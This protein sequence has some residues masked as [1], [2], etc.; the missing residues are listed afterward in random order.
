ML[1]SADAPHGGRTTA[2]GLSGF[3]QTSPTLGLVAIAAVAYYLGSIIG[4]PLRLRPSTTSVL[5][6]PNAILTA[7][8][9][10]VPI[11]RWWS[12]L[13][14]AAIAH[15]AIQLRVW[16]PEFVVSIFWTN[17]SEA[18][19]AAGV[20]RFLSDEP[21]RFD[22]LRRAS[23]FIMGA[24]AG[25]FFS[26]FLDAAVVTYFHH[27][28]YWAVWRLRFLSNLLA[29]LA[30]VSAIAGFLN[31][32]HR[33]RNWPIRVRLE[34]L[35]IGAGL[36][37]VSL[38]ARVDA[39]PIGLSNIALAFIPLLLWA[40]ARFGSA[41]VGMSVLGMVLF[42]TLDALYASRVLPLVPS[43][44]RVMALQWFLIAATVLLLCVGALVEER[45][46][47][48]EALR[49]ADRLKLSILAAVP[50]LL[51]VLR[52]D[53]TYVDYHARDPK[54]LFAPPASFIG[55][56]IRDVM[57]PDLATLFMDAL[58]RASQSDD[59][60]VVEYE[61]PM[62]DMTRK[63]EARIVRMAPDQLLTIVRDLTESKRAGELVHH[64]AG[65]LIA[66]QESERR[67]I[68]RELHDDLSQKIALLSIGIDQLAGEF[69]PAREH[70]NELTYRARAIAS[71][72]RTI[73]HELH[74]ARLE[75]VGLAPALRTL[76]LEMSRQTGVHVL[77]NGTPLPDSLDPEV[78]LS[79]YRIAQ[80]ALHNVARHSGARSADVQLT[81][82]DDVLTLQ[83]SDSGKGFRL[84]DHHA[85]LGLISMRERIAFMRGQ[86]VIQT[87]PGRGT[88]IR[89]QVP[90][91]L[92]SPP[93]VT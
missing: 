35:L 49:E 47:A 44:V 86:L 72:V 59:P 56:K 19:I 27:E 7:L 9:L 80:E 20:I 25:S 79:A 81:C 61:L 6:P 5:W 87:A 69:S 17:C 36:V 18:L 55:K 30:L 4:L 28:T 41:G 65:R 54:L 82:H 60:I 93:S 1:A 51:F 67:R 76:C 83:I 2:A 91:S 58:E 3:L 53:G 88:R 26:S 39:G 48:A 16:S 34:A 14:G 8:L 31:S 33:I 77:F 78:S 22:T 21:T 52:P 43:I 85:G 23:I 46:T 40:A 29:E 24:L 64:L 92:A 50:D 70:L 74:P 10:Y 66:S 12:V 42:V 37:L 73:S 68:A 90:L 57:P 63:F 75:L 89:V 32:G 71:D 11:R 15:L 13:A 45:R 62:T 38:G 84:E